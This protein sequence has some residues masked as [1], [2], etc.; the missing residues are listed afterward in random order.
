MFAVRRSPFTVHGSAF[1]VPRSA[2]SA[3]AK[4]TKDEGENE[5][6]TLNGEQ[7]TLNAT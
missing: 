4:K 7:R 5:P 2:Y 6:R 1:A 3:G